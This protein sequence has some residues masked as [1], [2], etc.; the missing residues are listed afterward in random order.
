MISKVIVV[1][2]LKPMRFEEDVEHG[3]ICRE[4]RALDAG[5]MMTHGVAL[6]QLFKVEESLPKEK[7]EKN[8]NWHI[9]ARSRGS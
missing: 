8:I 7:G 2:E 4:E 3:Y 9:L 1:Q 5:S 6:N